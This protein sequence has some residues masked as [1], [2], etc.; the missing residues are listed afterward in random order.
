MKTRII[1]AALLSTVALAP[2][3]CKTTIV[4]P[5]SQSRATYRMGK[6]TAEEP[7]EI[8]AVYTASEQAMSELGLKVVQRTKDALQAELV[9]RDAQD[10]KVSV[11]LLSITKDTTRVT[12]D[13]SPVEKAQ[14][15]HS[16][17]RDNLGL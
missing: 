4:D 12:I 13:I 10:K 15:I 8:D 5:V 14:R 1:W 2:L 16:A 7:R 11:K 17:I 6:L 9:A 3:G